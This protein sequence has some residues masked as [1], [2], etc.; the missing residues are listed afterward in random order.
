MKNGLKKYIKENAYYYLSFLIAAL[1]MILIFLFNKING[2]DYLVIRSDFLDSVGLL[3]ESVRTIFGHKSLFFNFT[4]G[5][6]LNNIMV[7]CGL[8]TPF[9]LIYLIF[10]KVNYNLLTAIIIVL[11]IGLA[12]FSFQ[13]FSKHILKNYSFSSVLIS[14]C[15]S[16]CAYTIEYGTIQCSWIEALIILPLLC[17]S[18]VECLEGNKRVKMILLYSYIF[19]TNFYMG[20]IIGFFSLLFVLGYLFFMHQKKIEKPIRELFSIFF[21]WMLGVIIAIM[22]S[23]FIWVPT[24]FFLMANRVPDSTEIVEINSSLLQILNSLFWGMDYGIEGNYAYIYCG[25][26]TLILAPLFFFNKKIENKEKWFWGILTS[27]ITISMVSNRLN[28]FWH[29]FDQPDDFWYRYS[30]LLCFCLCA[31]ATRELSVFSDDNKHKLIYVILL[32]ALFYQAMFHTASLWKLDQ[33]VLNTNFGFIFNLILLVTWC[34]ILFL[35]FHRN[36]I[37]ILCGILAIVLLGI[38]FI[39]GSKRQFTNLVDAKSYNTWVTDLEKVASEIKESDDSFYRTIIASNNAEYNTDTYLGLYGISDFGNQEKYAVRRFLS[40]IGFA[41]SPRVTCENGYNPVAEMLLGVKYRIYASDIMI[42][43]REIE[44]A[45]IVDENSE[46]SDTGSALLSANDD[47]E[48]MKDTSFIINNNA[49]NLG[50][51]VD[52][53]IILYEYSGRNVFENMNTLVSTM[54]GFDEACYVAVKEDDVNYS[55]DNIDLVEMDTGDLVFSRDGEEGQME[56]SIPARGYEKAYIQFEKEGPGIYGVDYFVMNAAN[57]PNGA[58]NRL[59]VSS[60]IEMKYDEKND[61]FFTTIGTY[62][63]Y[64]PELFVCDNI[65]VYYYSKEGLDKQYEELSK[66]QFEISNY[67]N[68]HVEGSIHVDGNKRVLFTTIPYDPGWKAFINGTE[69]EP[70]RVIDGTFMA[71]LLPNEGDYDIVFDFECPGLKIGII[72]SVCGILALLSVIFEKKLKNNKNNKDGE[73][74]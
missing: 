60:A 6:G 48:T 65:N 61:R 25:I 39:A 69:V 41:T 8:F 44:M 56:I 17:T 15:Y 32:L 59:G 50:Y 42:R 38:E 11:R 7:V 43:Q 55:S 27:I 14:V 45:S 16:L 37:R 28:T 49:L 46:D 72:V 53:N 29:V 26:L 52:G 71:I 62:Y 33:G 51:L 57:A 20:Y 2:K 19:F 1:L 10:N 54:S 23:A 35:R 66:N 9:N 18:I 63:E 31:V 68:G 47:D 4:T 21:N 70:I 24:L 64:S 73:N 22:L 13:Y 67:T 12:A 30:F 58:I 34:I 5:L 40:N 36:K 74:A 3:K